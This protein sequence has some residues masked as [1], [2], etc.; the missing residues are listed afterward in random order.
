MGEGGARSGGRDGKTD[1]GDKGE[2]TDTE[3]DGR[4]PRRKRAQRDKGR[5]K[6]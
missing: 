3:S 5:A 1:D 2:D 4:G 6:R